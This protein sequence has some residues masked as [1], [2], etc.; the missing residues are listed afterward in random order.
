MGRTRRRLSTALLFGLMS[1]CGSC[2]DARL[3]EDISTH[4]ASIIEIWDIIMWMCMVTFIGTELILFYSLV[5][6]RHKEGRKA[7]HF[8]GHH[9]LELGWTIVTAVILFFLAI[10]QIPAWK[11]A[12]IDLPAEKDSLV[13]RVLAKQFDW[14]FQ[15]AGP[16]GKFDTKDDPYPIK[17]LHVPVNKNVILKMRSIDVLHSL[18]IPNLWFKQDLVPGKQVTGWFQATKTTALAREE[19]KDSKFDYEIA[20]AELCGLSHYEMRAII[21]IHSAEDW[22][23]WEAKASKRTVEFFPG[24]PEIWHDNAWDKAFYYSE[25]NKKVR[26]LANRRVKK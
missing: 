20:C 1:L 15:Y 6:F 9:K 22:K 8:H 5:K 23:E 26:E 7:D 11:K 18:Y 16:D 4:G 10:Y 17:A 25:F 14:N 19:R 3:P 13:I 12:K 24:G 21:R 2:A